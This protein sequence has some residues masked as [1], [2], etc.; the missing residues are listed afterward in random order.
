MEV[1]LLP[2]FNLI[3]GPLMKMRMSGV[4]NQTI[5]ELAYFA[6][7]DAVHPRKLEAQQKLQPQ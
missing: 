1:S 4:V 2:V 3:M 6:E 7:N 5:E